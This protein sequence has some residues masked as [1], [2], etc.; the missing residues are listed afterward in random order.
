[1]KNRI[2]KYTGVVLFLLLSMALLQGVG[3]RAVSDGIS[4]LSASAVGSRLSER[5]IQD[6]STV[7]LR[8]FVFPDNG[9]L[10]ESISLSIPLQVRTVDRTTPFEN[11]FDR[12]CQEIRY[13]VSQN[14][15]FGLSAQ[16]HAAGH[17]LYVLCCLLI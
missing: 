14:V 8:K 4:D 13:K 16:L 17:Y 1:M 2:L 6:Y 5:D 10:R 9:C 15:V 3:D 12:F 11:F 7:T